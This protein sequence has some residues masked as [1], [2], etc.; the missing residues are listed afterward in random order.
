MIV[1]EYKVL[2]NVGISER[3][4]FPLLPEILIGDV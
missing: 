1:R 4:G 2:Y 3:R